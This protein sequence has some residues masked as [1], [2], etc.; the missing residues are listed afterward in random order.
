MTRVSRLGESCPSGPSSQA[1][2]EFHS[3][4][5]DAKSWSC[6]PEP[7]PQ[8]CRTWAATGAF[9]QLNAEGKKTEEIL[10]GA[11]NPLCPAW[12]PQYKQ[13]LNRGQTRQALAFPFWIFLLLWF[14]N[15]GGNILCVNQ[16]HWL[17]GQKERSVML[18]IVKRW[19][20][21]SGSY[22]QP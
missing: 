10:C 11:T 12:A 14:K 16:S 19:A 2:T 20:A 18:A 1:F 9:R 5:S 17:L 7:P 6:S 21:H 22:I 3:K 8:P 13:S 15:A 4:A